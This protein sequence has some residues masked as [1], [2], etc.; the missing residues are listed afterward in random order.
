[1][2]LCVDLSIWQELGNLGKQQGYVQLEGSSRAQDRGYEMWYEMMV[3]TNDG[4]I[5]QSS[6]VAED[7]VEL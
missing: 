3:G 7:L 1:M 6:Q 4:E 5:A 2:A